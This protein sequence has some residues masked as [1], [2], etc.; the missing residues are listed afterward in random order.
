M[1]I[2]GV[3]P[4]LK[5]ALA[6]AD[7]IDGEIG[8]ARIYDMPVTETVDGRP[9]PDAREILRIARKERADMIILE[10]V[11]PRP[12]AG[13]TS[14]WRFGVGYGLTR[15][16]LQLVDDEPRIHLVRPKAWKEKMGLSSDKK[17]SLAMARSL[18]SNNATDL[19]REKDDGR[20]EAC[21]LIRY[22]RDHLL[23]SAGVE[24]C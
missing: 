14:E 1:R 23:N 24:V 10:H 21:L 19:R 15:A 22:F 8:P 6:F 12:R 11:E 9:L 16:A 5:G 4:G 17:L 13:A 7:V 18:F 20:A 3:D 2:G